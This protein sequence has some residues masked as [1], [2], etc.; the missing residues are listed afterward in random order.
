MY[1]IRFLFLH[2]LLGSGL[3]L[4]WL[5]R[6]LKSFVFYVTRFV[7]SDRTR[8]STIKFDAVAHLQR[9]TTLSVLSTHCPIT[10]N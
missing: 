8:K 6:N 1:V 4:I 3:G 5:C 2:Y 10:T 9:H 7:L